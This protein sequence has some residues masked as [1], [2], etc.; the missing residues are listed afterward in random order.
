MNAELLNVLYK[1]VSTVVDPNTSNSTSQGD[2]SHCIGHA[3]EKKKKTNQQ[4]LIDKTTFLKPTSLR[5]GKGTQGKNNSNCY[6]PT[7]KRLHNKHPTDYSTKKQG[8]NVVFMSLFNQGAVNA[9]SRIKIQ[10]TTAQTSGYHTCLNGTLK[11][12]ATTVDNRTPSNFQLWTS[13]S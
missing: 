1:H 13:T 7:I 10:T 6:R 12:V 8:R 9:T 2:L 5:Q 4:R 11:S 3:E